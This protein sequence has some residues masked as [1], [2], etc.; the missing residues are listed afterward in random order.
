MRFSYNLFNTI[1]KII[2]TYFIAI[3]LQFQN[4]IM[5][6][7][8]CQDGDLCKSEIKKLYDSLNTVLQLLHLKYSTYLIQESP[9][10]NSSC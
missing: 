10:L 7:R 8:E 3:L 1:T 9:R 4:V 5:F 6:K 2:Y